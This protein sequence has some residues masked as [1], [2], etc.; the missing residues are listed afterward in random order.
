MFYIGGKNDMATLFEHVFD[1]QRGGYS[2]N[3]LENIKETEKQYSITTESTHPKG[4]YWAVLRKNQ[5][6]ELREEWYDRFTMYALQED[7][8]HF[9]TLL[10]ERLTNRAKQERKK[11]NKLIGVLETAGGTNPERS[12]TGGGLINQDFAGLTP[13]EYDKTIAGLSGLSLIVAPL[14]LNNNYEG[15]G[16]EDA[17][18]F[19]LDLTI[20]ADALTELKQQVHGVDTGEG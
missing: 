19:T 7:M 11:Y 6:D 2:V 1:P 4:G 14:L 9:K 13:E 20:A 17:A 16:I 8:Q 10:V 15:R 3:V 5:L 12:G 18:E